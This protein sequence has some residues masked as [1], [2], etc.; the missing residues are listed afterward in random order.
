MVFKRECA[1]RKAEKMTEETQPQ[2]EIVNCEANY[3]KKE[4]PDILKDMV[5][6]KPRKIAK[7]ILGWL[8]SNVENYIDN[9][10]KAFKLDLVLD[11]DESM[12]ETR[13]LQDLY[14]AIP[15]PE[16]AEEKELIEECTNC[17][18][19]LDKITLEAYEEMKKSDKLLKELFKRLVYYYELKGIKDGI[20]LIKDLCGSVDV[21]RFEYEAFSVGVK[22]MVPDLSYD[23]P[24]EES[25]VENFPPVHVHDLPEAQ[26][27][28][29]KQY[30]IPEGFT[31][32]IELAFRPQT[33]PT[34]IF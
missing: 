18:R 5:E 34:S 4:V 10:V 27:K 31:V 19:D 14:R 13:K 20:L 21:L 9:A 7:E 11:S 16:S 15:D 6:I 12:K 8:I 24:S 3:E 22:I 1:G 26:K 32:W 2:I 33:R 17:R 25:T 29:V 30:V 23:P 28:I